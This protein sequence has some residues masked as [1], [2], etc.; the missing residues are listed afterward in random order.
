MSKNLTETGKFVHALSPVVPST[1]SPK[2]VSLKGYSHAT[3]VV[4]CVNDSTGSAC[5]IALSQGTAVAGTSA[6]TLALASYWATTDTASSDTL[7]LTTATSDTFSSTATASKAQLYVIEVRAEDLDTTNGFDCFRVTVGDS[8][9]QTVSVVYYLSGT[10]FPQ[11]TPPT[12]I[13]D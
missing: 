4:S 10:R 3:V 11:A 7:T 12:A 6:K 2:W 13:L 8:A 1:A 5:A 9:H